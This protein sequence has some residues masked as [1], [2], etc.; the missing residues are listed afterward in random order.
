MDAVSAKTISGEFSRMLPW[1]E[2]FRRAGFPVDEDLRSR[3]RK[4]IESASCLNAWTFLEYFSMP[5]ND[6]ELA[7]R[8]DILSLYEESDSREA[9]L[10]EIFHTLK[11]SVLRNFTSSA[12]KDR[13]LAFLFVPVFSSVFAVQVRWTYIAYWCVYVLTC[14]SSN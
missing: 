13:F 7:H 1:L 5:F 2:L 6:P 11:I 8:R 3:T 10:R 14:H 12:R 9:F 4:S